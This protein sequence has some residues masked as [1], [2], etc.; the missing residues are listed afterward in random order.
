MLNKYYED[1]SPIKRNLMTITNKI[2]DKSTHLIIKE[3]DLIYTPLLQKAVLNYAKALY[4][5]FKIDISERVPFEYLALVSRKELT[6]KNISKLYSKN[7]AKLFDDDL[8][9][10]VETMENTDSEEDSIFAQITYN[11][12]FT[13]NIEAADIKAF[14]SNNES[15]IGLKKIAIP[16]DSNITHPFTMRQVMNEVKKIAEEQSLIYDLSKLNKNR[17]TL[18]NKNHNI[19]KKQEYCFQSI[20]GKTVYKKYSQAYIDLIFSELKKTPDLFSKNN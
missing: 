13:K 1:N 6:P 3:H 7:Y 8:R 19:L 4:T 20:I 5:F 15:A 18:F 16:K 9:F 17:L 14:Y 12:A 11:L 10:I 2:R